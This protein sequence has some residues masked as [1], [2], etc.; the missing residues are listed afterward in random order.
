MSLVGVPLTAAMPE[1]RRPT[2]TTGFGGPPG[3]E[4]GRKRKLFLLLMPKVLN[5]LWAFFSLSPVSCPHSVE[6]STVEAT[7]EASTW[8]VL[9]SPHHTAGRARLLSVLGYWPPSLDAACASNRSR[10]GWI[11]S[12]PASINSLPVLSR[13]ILTPGCSRGPTICPSSLPTA[14]RCVSHSHRARHDPHPQEQGRRKKS[15]TASVVFLTTSGAR[16][17]GKGKPVQIRH[18]PA[19]VS[20][21][22]SRG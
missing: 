2:P 16:Y 15:H 21:Q 9:S 22:S 17:G 19:T 5:V 1:V 4:D 11:S 14:T 6:I 12:I 20:G 18:G 10:P 8:G 7:R 3:C 13:T